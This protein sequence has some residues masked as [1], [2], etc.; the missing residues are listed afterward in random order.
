MGNEVINSNYK[1]VPI[2]NSFN[3]LEEKFEVS[4]QLFKKV[5]SGFQIFKRYLNDKRKQRVKNLF[6]GYKRLTG[7]M[8]QE[9]MSLGFHIMDDGKHYKITCKGDPRYMA[10]IGKTPSDNR[11]GSN[12]VGMINKIMI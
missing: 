10:T 8:K 12:N 6:K 1:R 5:A 4:N 2:R 3:P 11:A 9:L 7:T